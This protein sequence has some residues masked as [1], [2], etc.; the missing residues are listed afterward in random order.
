[1]LLTGPSRGYLLSKLRK[2]KIDLK[3][4]KVDNYSMMPLY[5]QALDLYLITSR[6]EGGPK[7]LLESIASSI[8]VVSTKVGMAE[9]L[10]ASSHIL[11]NFD[12]V[13]IS[14]ELNEMINTPGFLSPP[15]NENEIIKSIDF[16]EIA[17]MHYDKV[18]SQLM[19]I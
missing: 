15:K 2:L 11:S 17:K 12:P 16:S 6:E 9:D 18:Y 13:T 7:G 19:K 3:Y 14:S 10:L 8:P 5:Y 4:F 1:V